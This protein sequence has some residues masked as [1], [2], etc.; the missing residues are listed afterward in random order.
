MRKRLLSDWWSAAACVL[1]VM[2]ATASLAQNYEGTE[3][4]FAFINNIVPFANE[5]STFDV[6]IQAVEDATV[7]VEFGDPADPFYLIETLTVGAGTSGLITFTTPFLY[8]DEYFDIDRRTFRATSTGLVRLYV[9]HNRQFYSDGTA[10]LPSN[11]LGTQYRAMAMPAQNVAFENASLCKIVAVEDGTEVEVITVVDTPLGLAGVPVT[12]SLNAREAITLAAPQPLDLTGTLVTA[13]AGKPLTVFSGNDA[14]VIGPVACEASSHVYEQ[15]TPI[16]NW[17]TLHPIIPAPGSGGEYMR[18]MAAEDGTELYDGCDLIVEIDAGETYDAYVDDP[19]VLTS[20]GPVMV[21]MFTVGYACNGLAAGDPNL[22]I[23]L[24]FEKAVQ[25]VQVESSYELNEFF[26]GVPP[27]SE[28]F[29]NVSMPTDQ[30]DQLVV[31]GAP[32]TNWQ[33]FATLPGMSYASVAI[34]DVAVEALT[35]SSPA[36]FWCE[37]VGLGA[38]DA[39]T[40]SLGTTTLMELPDAN[41]LLVDLGPDFDLCPGQE[42]ELDPGLGIAGTWQDGSVQETFLATEPGTYT[43]TIDD[44]CGVGTGTITVGTTDGPALDLPE[45]YTLCGEETL[46]IGV[47]AAP[48]VSYVWNTGETTAE[49]TVDAEGTYELTASVGEDCTTTASTTVTADDLPAV[50]IDGPENICEGQSASLTAD[51]GIDGT[52]TWNNG[53][54]NATLEVTVPGTYSVSFTA[55]SGCTSEGSFTLGVLPSPSLELLAPQSLCP[56]ET[57]ELVALFDEGILGWEDGSSEPVRV[58]TGPGTYQAVVVND[59]GCERSETAVIVAAGLP[60][61]TTSDISI[62]EG[63]EAALLAVAPG[64]TV[65]WIDGPEGATFTVDEA[66]TYTAVATNDCGTRQ[67]EAVVTLRD[68][69]CPIYVPNAFT[70]DGDG[71]NDLFIPVFGCDPIN[72]EFI[73]FDRWGQEVF[74]T[75]D[76]SQGWNGSG[77]GRS[78][79]ADVSMYQWIIRYANPN[80]AVPETELLRG[81]VV[82]I[83]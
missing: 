26:P 70:P 48:G 3:F 37:M 72:Y 67:A 81:T 11:E 13:P 28:W 35:A 56:D 31:N 75:A 24:P 45:T 14:I 62:C 41:E 68:C 59:F 46:V 21:G 9:F 47:E 76:P 29:L 80:L 69:D 33:P 42:V 8:Q 52:Y 6:S 50:N 7:T 23:L 34:P 79:Y 30:T 78:H 2:A 16:S 17:G 57:G 53:Q 1:M 44:E 77:T 64:A 43:V 71:L 5:P 65:A 27:N 39:K 19:F 60:V 22:R 54:T 55:A 25:A 12:V 32:V 18:V 73:I 38:A 36:P 83:R 58:V 15:V 74:S 82:L 10:V 40:M 63:Q 49:I 20:T 66:G 61:I 51:A 4:H